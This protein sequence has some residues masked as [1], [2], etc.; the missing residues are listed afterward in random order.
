MNTKDG[1][2]YFLCGIGIGAT[3]GLLYAPK[4]GSETRELLR[5]RSREG[6]DYV[7]NTARDATDVA[8]RTAERVR[9]VFGNLTKV[10]VLKE[11]IEVGKRAYREATEN[12]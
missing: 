4:A 11:A 1:F 3:V 6:S 2:L 8:K 9:T 5:T 12:A 7:K 10:P